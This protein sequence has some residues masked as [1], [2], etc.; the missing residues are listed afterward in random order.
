KNIPSDQPSLILERWPDRD[1][2]ILVY[3]RTQRRATEVASFLYRHGYRNVYVLEGGILG[4]MKKGYP[5][6]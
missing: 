4:W 3:C 6:E 2:E 5:S 1:T